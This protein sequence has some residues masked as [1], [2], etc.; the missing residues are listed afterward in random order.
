MTTR[1]IKD[2]DIEICALCGDKKLCKRF[3]LLGMDKL[4]REKLA[5]NPISPTDWGDVTNKILARIPSLIEKLQSILDCGDFPRTINIC[6][7]VNNTNYHCDNFDP[8]AQD[9][10]H[11]ISDFFKISF[12]YL[13]NLLGI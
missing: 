12:D 8:D 9:L 2:V 7:I 5:G 6:F 13:A 4:L 1:D 11:Q 3:E 10:T